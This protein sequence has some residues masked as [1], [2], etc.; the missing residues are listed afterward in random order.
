M[1]K[2]DQSNLP[3]WVQSAGVKHPR[4]MIALVLSAGMSRQAA[5]VLGR[6]VADSPEGQHAL[7]VLV[8]NFNQLSTELAKREGWTEEMLL[9]C[10]QEIKLAFNSR[11]ILSNEIH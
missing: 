3:A 6:Q 8:N 9:A 1:E 10:E 5:E 11:I 2:T 4:A 7:R